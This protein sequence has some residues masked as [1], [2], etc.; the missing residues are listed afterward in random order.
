MAATSNFDW[1]ATPVGTPATAKTY[2][3]RPSTPPAPTPTA[4][5]PT[6]SAFSRRENPIGAHHPAS[7][8][9]NSG[10]QHKR[11]NSL[12]LTVVGAAGCLAAAG[13][14]AFFFR[15]QLGSPRQYF[16]TKAINF[17]GEHDAV[18]ARQ[19]LAQGDGEALQRAS[20]EIMLS[21]W[22]SHPIYRAVVL[23]LGPKAIKQYIL[24]AY[25]R[26][27]GC[28]Y[29]SAVQVKKKR[30]DLKAV[31]LI[32]LE[33]A[34]LVGSM[35]LGVVLGRLLYSG[36]NIAYTNQQYLDRITTQI[37]D[38]VKANEIAA[39]LRHA[40][41]PTGN[42][43]PVANYGIPIMD[44][45]RSVPIPVE[46][47]GSLQHHQD[48]LQCALFRSL[49]Y[50]PAHFPDVMAVA[51]F[52]LPSAVQPVVELTILGYRVLSSHLMVVPKDA[53]DA[54]AGGEIH[55][56]RKRNVGGEDVGDDTRTPVHGGASNTG[57]SRS[58]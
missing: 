46:G 8:N 23:A 29:R 44:A 9:A 52:Y 30:V 18:A 50:V 53:D 1:D 39:Q 11:G 26:C 4:S 47:E 35:A 24:F 37:V 13:G 31:A 25:S 17:V 10:R 27:K 42:G 45:M 54:D 16:I 19:I 38:F 2:G 33:S 21:I 51:A 28:Y 34:L 20:V 15:K 48:W 5:S 22:R 14:I 6:P 7:S 56:G 49:P 43:A 32:G 36:V 41:S 57:R 58:E 40:A 55:R 3:T 12:L